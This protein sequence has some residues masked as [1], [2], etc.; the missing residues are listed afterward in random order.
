VGRYG[1][2]SGSVSI[3]GAK[4]DVV[5]TSF[6]TP[7]VWPEISGSSTGT[8]VRRRRLNPADF[9]R[10]KFPLPARATQEKLRAVKAKAE[11]ARKL[12]APAQ[13]ELNAM[14]P[15]VLDRAFRGEL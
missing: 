8:N 10:Y 2:I 5:V 14:L 4:S 12:R 6:C 9:L 13:K 7:S 11:E 1:A 3:F 15:A